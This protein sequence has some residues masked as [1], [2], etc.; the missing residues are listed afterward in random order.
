MF[1][2]HRMTETTNNQSVLTFGVNEG[3]NL[4]QSTLMDYS[5]ITFSRPTYMTTAENNEHRV[6]IQDLN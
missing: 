5:T 1:D 2:Q 3:D 6:S 4:R